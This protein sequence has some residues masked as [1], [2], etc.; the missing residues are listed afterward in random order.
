MARKKKNK[1]NKFMRWLA[2]VAVG[3]ALAAVGV[4]TNHISTPFN[5]EVASSSTYNKRLHSY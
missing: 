4:N 5:N 3:V 1:S 2:T